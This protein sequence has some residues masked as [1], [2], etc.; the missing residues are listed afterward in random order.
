[1]ISIYNDDVRVRG[2]ME[3]WKVEA[4]FLT[5]YLLR[6]TDSNEMLRDTES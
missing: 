5:E 2:W 3:R 6:D 4:N 1:M